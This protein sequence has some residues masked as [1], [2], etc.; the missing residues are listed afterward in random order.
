MDIIWQVL[1]AAWNILADSS[2]Y[3]LFGL[4]VGGL[5]KAFLDPDTVARHLG[6]GRYA[7]AFKAAMWGIPLPLCCCG[8]LP[9][10]AALKRQS[11]SNGAVIFFFSPLPR[12]AWTPSPSPTL[13]WTP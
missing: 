10:S 5:L 6:Q 11:A 2:V 9:A 4:L 12:R 3:V 7:P 8:V 1:L 13:S